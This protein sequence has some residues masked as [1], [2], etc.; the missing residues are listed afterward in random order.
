MPLALGSNITDLSAAAFASHAIGTVS[1]GSDTF[2]LASA[3]TVYGA[4]SYRDDGTS[5]SPI[6]W[7]DAVGHSAVGTP[8][9]TVPVIGTAMTTGYSS[10]ARTYD[11]SITVATVPEPASLVLLITGLIGLLCYAWRKRK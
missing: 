6:Q 9:G 2:T 11:F 10:L 5:S 4:F 7:Q 1:A 8:N 3:T